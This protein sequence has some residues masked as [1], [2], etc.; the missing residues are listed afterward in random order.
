MMKYVEIIRDVLLSECGVN[1]C[2]LIINNI[3]DIQ[4]P[5]IIITASICYTK[6]ASICMSTNENK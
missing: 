2:C 6:T 1:I 3:I 5:H 4:R